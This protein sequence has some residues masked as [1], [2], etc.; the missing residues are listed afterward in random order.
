MRIFEEKPGVYRVWKKTCDKCGKS[1]TRDED[2]FEFQEFLHWENDC[3]YNSVFGDG[4]G[5]EID[6]C[7]NCVKEVLGPYLFITRI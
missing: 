5:L 3:G 7:Q 4:S 6:L 1:A 2:P